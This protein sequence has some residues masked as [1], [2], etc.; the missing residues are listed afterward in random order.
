MKLFNIN[1]NINST[2]NILKFL[3]LAFI[4]ILCIYILYISSLSTIEGFAESKDCSN[5]QIMPSSGNCI[6]LYDFSYS[7]SN[8][9]SF[10]DDKFTISFEKIDTSYIFCPYE[11]KCKGDDYNNIMTPE[12]RKNL[13]NEDIELGKGGYDI[14]CCSGEWLEDNVLSYKDVYTNFNNT[15]YGPINESINRKCN[16]FKNNVFVNNEIDNVSFDENYDINYNEEDKYKINAII[17]KNNYSNI[18]NFCRTH[19]TEHPMYERYMEN[20]DFSGMLFKRDISSSGHIL[21]DPKLLP[22]SN[23]PNDRTQSI[24]ELLDAQRMLSISMEEVSYNIVENGITQQRTRFETRSDP[25]TL[26]QIKDLNNDLENL[27]TLRPDFDAKF[28]E[29]QNQLAELYKDSLGDPLIEFIDYKYY[30]YKPNSDNDGLTQIEV[31]KNSIL[32]EY[33]LLEDEFLNCFGDISNT[34]NL[35][36]ASGDYADMLSTTGRKNFFGISEDASYSTQNNISLG[37]GPSMDL[38]AE[39]RHLESVNVG[40]TA[41]TGVID[42]YLRAINGFYEKQM[43]NMLGPRTHALNQQVVFENDGLKTKESTFFV[44]D[45]EPNNDYECQPSITGNDKFKTCGPSAYYSEFKP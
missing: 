34:Q 42:Q 28:I 9:Q 5:C 39:F 18:L 24:Q 40:G 45:N 15:T 25:N 37:Y 30:P 26:R 16:E 41:P 19:D 31:Y 38:A 10:I 36:F 1:L 29:K 33:V 22:K 23:D 7:F 4:V 20:K 11:P 44:Y 2:K 17:S 8:Q 35:R 12:E 43:S 32:G 14:T 3:L 21:T 27:N 6:K 13:S